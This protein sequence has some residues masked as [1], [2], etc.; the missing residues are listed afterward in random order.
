MK[1][2]PNIDQK[3]WRG[4]LHIGA[5]PHG[6][7]F[8]AGDIHGMFTELERALEACEFDASRDRLLSVGDLVDR[9]TESEDALEWL[10]SGRIHAA[11]LGNHEAM[12][13]GALWGAGEEMRE[14]AHAFWREN[15]GEWW[16]ER[17]RSSAEVL[18]WREALWDLPLA[19]TLETACRSVGVVHALPFPGPW[20]ETVR[21]CSADEDKARARV[22]WGHL[23]FG[24]KEDTPIVCTNAGEPRA[25]IAGH[26]ASETPRH[27]G[28][29][30]HIDTG[31]G[32][33][34]VLARVTLACASTNPITYYA[35]PAGGARVWVPPNADK[36]GESLAPVPWLAKAGLK[37]LKKWWKTKTE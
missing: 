29:T 13:I 34:V 21:R 17:E 31:A 25:I 3:T 4:H 7:D 22:L 10:E 8:I 19:I 27:N 30:V 9:G 37:A 28:R 33:D 16:D 1:E 35:S 23:P 20:S 15:G 12:M 5:N 2:E 24:E 32:L 26:F 36:H 18:R 6:R 11:T 14:R